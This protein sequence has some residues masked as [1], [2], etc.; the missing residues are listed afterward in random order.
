MKIRTKA[1]EELI[2]KQKIELEKA[3]AKEN[4]KIAKIHRQFSESIIQESLK[5]D[6]L[7]KIILKREVLK[8]LFKKLLNFYD[9]TDKIDKPNKGDSKNE[10][11]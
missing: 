3:I 9:E 11:K 5:D 8:E 2:Q 1:I 10:T 7:K 4:S 6:E